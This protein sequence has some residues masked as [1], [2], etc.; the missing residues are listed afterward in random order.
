M[1]RQP[2]QHGFEKTTNATAANPSWVPL[3]DQQLPALCID[4]L[5]I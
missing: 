3:T 1:D 2:A 4:S 5:A